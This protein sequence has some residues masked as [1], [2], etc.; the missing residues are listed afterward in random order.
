M[1]EVLYEKQGRIAYLTLNRP[2]SLN[3]VDGAVL[4]GLSQ[5]WER[6]GEDKE[7]WVAVLSGAGGRAFSVGFDLKWRGEEPEDPSRT[8]ERI[9]LLSPLSH[10]IWKPVIA[11]VGGYCLGI[12]W[13]LV[14]ECDLRVASDDAQFG[15]PEARLNIVSMFTGLVGHHLPPAL[16][17]EMVMTGERISAQRAYEMGFLNRVVPKDKLMS[18]ATSLA[19]SVCNSGPVAVRRIKELFYRSR[20]LSREQSLALMRDLTVD[21]AQMEDSREGPRAFLE[22]RKPQWQEK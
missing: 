8:M 17:L 22:K 7:A 18:E 14:Q 5:A 11:A 12:G 16:A 3:A 19:E 20:E 10:Q 2:Q 1:P 15:I 4:D 9:K 13:W 21:L 6:F